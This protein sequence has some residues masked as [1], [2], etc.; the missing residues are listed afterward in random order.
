MPVG[1]TQLYPSFSSVSAQKTWILNG[2]FVKEEARGQ[3][4]G[5]ALLDA[6]KA[7]THSTGAK[8]LSLETAKD[9]HHAQALY[10]SL[11]YEKDD[12]Y[13]SYFLTL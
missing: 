9:N 13:Y 7:F 5:K 11:G 8:G 6:A 4:A 3:G 1:F 10:E 2:L 12:R